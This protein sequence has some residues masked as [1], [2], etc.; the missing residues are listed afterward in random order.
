MSDT[1]IGNP[2]RLPAHIQ[3]FIFLRELSEVYL[4]LDHISGQWDKKLTGTDTNGFADAVLGPNWLEKVCEIGWPPTGSEGQKAQQAATLLRVKDRLNSAA[5]PAS[6]A[7]IAFTLL[8]S[9]EDNA[10]Q[11]IRSRRPWYGIFRKLLRVPYDNKSRTRPDPPPPI[12]GG[13]NERGS[14]NEKGSGN[15]GGP[16][17]QSASGGWG[18]RA[19]SRTSLAR[20][21]YPGLIIT[22]NRF[23]WQIRII[24][25]LLL[26]WLI[27]TC[28]LSWNVGAG[29]AISLQF[30]ALE[31]QHAQILKDIDKAESDSAKN[32]TASPQTD[33]PAATI[34]ATLLKN[35]GWPRSVNPPFT[36]DDGGI[37]KLPTNEIHLCDEIARYRRDYAATR[38]NLADWLG[39]WGWLKKLSYWFCGGRCLAIT[40]GTR[41]F[42]ENATNEQWA[43]ILPEVLASAVL[44]LCYGFLGAGAAVV[45]SLWAKMRD[46]LLSPRDL[47]LALGQLALGAVIG[48]SIGLF[49]TPPGTPSQAASGITGSVVL[50]ASALSFIAGF[51]VEGVFVALESLIRRVF[52]L[53]EPTKTA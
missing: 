32:G 43:G 12:D 42:P 3:D 39:V 13:G 10:D 51:G 49:V 40:D 46:S 28:T 11:A 7:T 53:P 34:G 20:L 52:N 6:G 26:F 50:T 38:E 47:T 33:P 21:A 31:L 18:N 14:G 45:R 37:D 48:A 1:A 35:C 23:K 2:E 30:G 22:A 29:H 9:G 27:C 15:G 41:A 16:P 19:P 5:K 8:V 24:I 44:P 17:P 36:S 25:A 4:L